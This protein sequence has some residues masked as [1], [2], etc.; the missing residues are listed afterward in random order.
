MMSKG[1]RTY[2][3]DGSN[4]MILL[5]TNGMSHYEDKFLSTDH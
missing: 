1:K 2:Y 5:G 3:A 4:T